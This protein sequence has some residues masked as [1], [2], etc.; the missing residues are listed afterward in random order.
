MPRY[1][2]FIKFSHFG[3]TQVWYIRAEERYV[4]LLKKNINPRFWKSEQSKADN[5]SLH[6]PVN[7]D[8]LEK[9]ERFLIKVAKAQK[10]ADFFRRGF[11]SQGKREFDCSR[12]L[13]QLSLK[14][15]EPIGYGINLVP[16][17][18]I[19][20]L[21]ICRQL[22]G[23]VTA[24]NFLENLKDDSK[25][26]RLIEAAARD[27]ALM[28][29]NNLIHRDAHFGNILIDPAREDGLY[30]IDNDL[31]KISSKDRFRSV[32]I[33]MSRIAS[34]KHAS[35]KLILSTEEVKLMRQTLTQHLIS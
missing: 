24:R 29:E 31:K 33:L 17:S 12:T 23:A 13:I 19:D 28:L 25:R 35:R 34:K 5:H 14:C 27:L 30:W 11:R 21:Y 15:P 20:S 3:L 1:K 4:A 7:F 22:P 9:R 18:R 6:F 32:D 26:K 2:V 10:P 16:W 8:N